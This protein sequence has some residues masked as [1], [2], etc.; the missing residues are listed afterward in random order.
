MKNFLFLSFLAILSVW[1]PAQSVKNVVP[2][3][4]M[5]K[6]YEEVKTPY[7]YGLVMAPPG[8][9]KKIDCPGVFRRNGLWYM[10]YLIF[11]GRGYETWL[12]KSTN[13]LDW[14]TLG[15]ILSFSDDSTQW[16]A[17]QK[18]GF[19]ALQDY[20]W[21]GSYE[22]QKYKDR[23]WMSYLGGKTKGY[24][25]GL[26]SLGIA[27]NTGDPAD[28]N[29][30]KP[31]AS[32]VM[33]S[34]D[35]DVRW[36]ENIKQFK[37]TVMRDEK[38][39]TGHPFVMFYN[40]AGDSFKTAP[41]AERIG[42]AVSDDMEHWQRYLKNPVLDHHRGITGDP[43]IQKIGNTWVMFYFGAF[44]QKDGKDGAFNRFACSYDLVNWTD[45]KGANLVEPSEH[46]DDQFAH[47]SCV[48]KWNGVVYHFYCAVNKKDQR[49]IA[50]ATSRDLGKSRLSFAGNTQTPEADSLS[51]ISWKSLRS[52]FSL[53]L[54]LDPPA[55][56][57][58][59][60]DS[61]K[62][63]SKN[64]LVY[65]SGAY[66][67]RFQEQETGTNEKTIS[68]S[69]SRSDGRMF[70]ILENRIES[71]T[72]YAGIYKI[73]NPDV[74][75]Q[76]SYQIDLPF[77][78]GGG[79]RAESNQ[80]VIW[81]QQTDGSNTLTMGLLDQLPS[82]V[83]EGTTYD[84]GNGGEAPGIANSYVRV[85]FT[86]TWPSAVPVKEYKDALYLNANPEISWFEAL[87]AY[88]VAVDSFRKYLPADA[89]EWA[90][91]PMWHSWYAHGDLIDEAQ[92]RDDARR[93]H[94][95]GVKTIEIDAGWNIPPGIP[96]AFEN[97][98]DYKF[99][100]QRFPDPLEMIESMHSSGQ[101][102]VLHVAPLLMGKN[103][104]A[105]EKMKDCMISVGGVAD[106]HLDPRLKK[107]HDYLLDAW[108][109]LFTKYKV[110]GLWYDF[111]EIP[112][113]ADAP[114]PG[115][116]IISADLN[117]A[118]TLLLQ[119]LY[120]KATGLNPNAVI[121]LRRPSANLNAKTYCT[122]L[123]PM[124]TPQDYNMNRRDV[125][126]LKTLGPGVL[127]HAC[128]TSW[129]ISESSV[130]VARQMASIVMAGV[131]AFSVKLAESPAE[132]DA[133]IKAWLGFY[134]SS[135]QDLVNGEMTPLLP[136]PPS[137]A[138]RIEN[139]KQA[140]FGFFEALPGLTQ[141]S[142]KE[143]NKITI[144]NA[145]SNRTVTRLEKV[146][147]EWLA[148]V[149]G[150]DWKLVSQTLLKSDPQGGLNLNIAGPT[151]CHEIVLIKQ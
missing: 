59:R 72:S 106:P 102:L 4:E 125:I 83:F 33:M 99:D 111:L 60:A 127:T 119:E 101:R 9:S 11:D 110:D 44:W 13:L 134:E 142:S 133:I 128:C 115:M 130:N 19:I 117:T 100:P 64:E 23:Y 78:I 92:I 84:P 87:K 107:V 86:R 109:Q 140:F 27:C 30:W 69:M 71:K 143:I 120:R 41:N 45:W 118:Y 148:K 103:A 131:P 50:V 91:N 139:G 89:G 75:S 20:Q 17:D 61:E 3:A 52:F 56:K 95:L 138:I 42:M 49:G 15:R 36:W 63:Q 32:P 146:E 21:G 46:Y 90:L 62:G 66:Q 7:K 70:R 12:A 113:N 96:Y 141:V 73:F 114:K 79:A 85:V 25:L 126:Y 108:E 47:K 67:F 123:W 81:M 1:S 112:D 39:V 122:H 68:F 121:I 58:S 94:D 132:H 6:I 105:W 14:V 10:T 24:E 34:T 26:L 77:R 65:R 2:D 29:Q 40:A 55:G 43:F 124:D 22:I 145:F 5:Q 35:K 93:A 37:S 16:D 28:I 135:R 48:V 74:L 137:A 38:K 98:G 31:S 57:W 18:A 147:G 88:S 51:S 76:Q 8:D 151:G 116:D 136:T 149:Y 150:Q 53:K 54:T 129:P 82:T 80:P 97:E 104:K 144:I